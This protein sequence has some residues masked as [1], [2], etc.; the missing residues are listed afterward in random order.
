MSSLSPDQFYGSDEA[1]R[2]AGGVPLPGMEKRSAFAQTAPWQDEKENMEYR[3]SRDIRNARASAS[4]PVMDR[5]SGPDPHQMV[6]GVHD[7]AENNG[8]PDAHGFISE[9]QFMQ[10][11]ELDPTH[12]GKV[13][14]PDTNNLGSG[15]NGIR[16]K[17]F[18][19]RYGGSKANNPAVQM[20][21]ASQPTVQ[22]RSDALVH[23]GQST[24]ETELGKA[25]GSAEYQAL[26]PGRREGRE[27]VNNIRDDLEAG[28]EIE[29]PAW[30]IKHNS[31]L[32]S[33]DGHH[34][35]VASREAGKSHYPAKVWDLDA[36]RKAGGPN[37]ET[38]PLPPTPF[39][40]KYAS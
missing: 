16:A 23:T 4:G 13:E 29:K 31:R 8:Q 37:P 20:H 33:L 14:S 39:G 10:R 15:G 11:G 24:D 19:A 25:H 30:L 9:R 7:L 35:I 12:Y 38:Q 32:Y 34:R 17:N 22:V 40:S 27:R 3:A 1:E 5:W 36:Q 6:M 2:A 21:W 28:N 26:F 18:Y